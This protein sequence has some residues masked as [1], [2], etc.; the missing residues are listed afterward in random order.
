MTAP[1]KPENLKKVKIATTIE[2]QTYDRVQKF[3]KANKTQ[4]SVVVDNSLN[5]LMNE[6]ELSDS[7]EYSPKEQLAI[8]MT[9]V[10]N[11]QT[12]INSLM[13]KIGGQKT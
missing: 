11:L 1:N 10:S 6:Q 7:E 13:L 2:R 12:E 9:K 5:F 4:L 8:L 3:I